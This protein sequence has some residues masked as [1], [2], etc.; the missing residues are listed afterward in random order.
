MKIND[1]NTARELEIWGLAWR[2]KK[3]A[4]PWIWRKS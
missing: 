4:G 1:M 3:S 2:W